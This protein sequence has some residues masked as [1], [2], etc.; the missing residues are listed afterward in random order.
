MRILCFT[1]DLI[2]LRSTKR[3]N[4]YKE[5]INCRSYV[6]NTKPPTFDYIL[7]LFSFLCSC[8]QAQVDVSYYKLVE[9]TCDF[10]TCNLKLK[11]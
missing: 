8:S 10:N 5:I 4:I 6:Q 11:M 9:H 7:H 2:V 3:R 1:A